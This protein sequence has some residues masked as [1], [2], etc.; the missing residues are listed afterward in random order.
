LQRSRR[1]PVGTAEL[2]AGPDAA[3]IGVSP[4]LIGASQAL[5]F[6]TRNPLAADSSVVLAW[7]R[8]NSARNGLR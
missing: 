3:D 5:V 2:G 6:S 4:N 7:P 1:R 8:A